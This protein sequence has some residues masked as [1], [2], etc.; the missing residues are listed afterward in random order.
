MPTGYIRYS[1]FSNDDRDIDTLLNSTYGFYL[2]D[3]SVPDNMYNTFSEFP[4]IFQNCT[5]KA[6]KSRKLISCMSANRILIYHPLLK[7]Y[8]EHGL[9]VSKVY[10]MIDTKKYKC[11]ESFTE[12]V[13][14]ERRKG[15]EKDEYKI[16]GNEMKDI[17]NSSYGRS[18]MNKSKHTQTSYENEDQARRSINT[19]YFVDCDQYGKIYEVSKKK[20]VIKQSIPIQMSPA[21][22]WSSP[23]PLLPP[24]PEP[25][26]A[27]TAASSGSGN[28]FNLS[29][30]N[31]APQTQMAA[32]ESA[33]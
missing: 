10:G 21:C 9:I 20:H 29:S 11:F 28:L 31:S 19:P 6:D 27:S 15:D 4:P 33:S 32:T 24:Q 13:S 12:L 8:I 26:T 7:W 30:A 18:C 3:I 14:D 2:V 23:A 16:I 25:V 5:I 22:R 17:G 1:E